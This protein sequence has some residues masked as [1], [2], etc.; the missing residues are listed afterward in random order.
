MDA[1]QTPSSPKQSAG[2]GLLLM[3]CPDAPLPAASLAV[4]AAP[5]L[6]NLL[7]PTLEE[8]RLSDVKFDRSPDSVVK[9]DLEPKAPRIPG[10]YTVVLDALRTL[11]L[12]TH[13][14]PIFATPH[15]IECPDLARLVVYGWPEPEERYPIPR[16]ATTRCTLDID[17][18]LETFQAHWTYGLF[19]GHAFTLEADDATLARKQRQY[20]DRDCAKDE[21][22][23]MVTVVLHSSESRGEEVGPVKC[24]AA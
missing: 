12:Y 5:Q 21:N 1:Q 23:A 3:S 19:L 17:T 11:K 15:L 20:S 10:T 14:E 4:F 2:Y 24:S 22:I 18:Q 6:R 8:L 13:L 7:P 16:D 9:R